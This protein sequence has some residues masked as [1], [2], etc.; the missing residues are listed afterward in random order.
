MPK[1][2]PA[3]RQYLAAAALAVAALGCTLR[4]ENPA[5]PPEP[6]PTETPAP[7]VPEPPPP[8]APDAIEA[9]LEQPPPPPTEPEPAVP[10]PPPIMGANEVSLIGFVDA[11]T[12]EVLVD[13]QPYVLPFAYLPPLPAP[14]AAPSAVP[15]T[16]D[17]RL[18]GLAVKLTRAQAGP[19]ESVFRL[20]AAQFQDETQAHGL[21]HIYVEVLDEKGQRII[22]Q[23]IIQA[24]RDGQIVFYTRD[25]PAPEFA[26][27]V[28]MYGALGTDNYHIYVD[29]LPSDT[30]EGLGL[31]G[32]RL[33]N[34]LLT[35]QRQ[36]N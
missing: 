20:T 35:F 10:A 5:P 2:Q 29:G 28:P 13:G 23:P 25:K 7:A 8:P 21:H 27:N 12:V 17:T 18:D 16:W 32:G 30:V 31:P 14:A 15:S 22:G 34:Y 3:G 33:V 26:A 4:F 9:S 11:Q 6:T 24:W 36:R 1:H 19:G